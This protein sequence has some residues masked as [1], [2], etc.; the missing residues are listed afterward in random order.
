[1]DLAATRRVTL[2][3]GRTASAPR[4]ILGRDLFWWAHR[5]GLTHLPARSWLARRMQQGP[6]GL[7]GV[8]PA[9]LAARHRITL[10]PR[11]IG[12]TGDEA[13]F[14]DGARRRFAAVVWATGFRPE[15]ALVAPL[16]AAAP[17]SL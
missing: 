10:A 8:T 1:Q 16:C 4:Q 14:V 12:L 13:R 2:S 17:G 7:I 9:E 11:T 5:L 6:D 3:L 15:Y